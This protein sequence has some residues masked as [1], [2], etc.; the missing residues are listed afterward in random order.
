MML[1]TVAGAAAAMTLAPTATAQAQVPTGAATTTKS[2]TATVKQVAPKAYKA[3]TSKITVSNAAQRAVNVALAQVGK[4]YV[5]GATGPSSF[6]CS[7]LVQYAYKQAGVS[8]PRTTSQQVK[9]GVAVTASQM[10]PGDLVFAYG[11]GHVG[12]YVGN[13]KYVHAPTSGDVVKV[14]SVPYGQITAIRHVT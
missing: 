10:Q 14:A 4:P 7:G 6:D 13:G 5:W 11:G 1:A 8:L 2:T 3:T 12:I 9:V